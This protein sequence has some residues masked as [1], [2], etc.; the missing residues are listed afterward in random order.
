M[1]TFCASG[2]LSKFAAK[3][4]TDKGFEAYSLQG[5]MK[6]WN[7]AFD[8]A[9]LEFENFKIIQIRRNAKGC[10]S[11]IIGSKN[12]ALV[13]DAS[14]DPA[15]Y[16]NIA[17]NEGWK[18]DFVTDTHIHADY[19]SRTKDLSSFTGAAH[20]LNSVANVEYPFVPFTNNEI[21]LIGDIEIKTISTPGHTWESTTFLV[22][23]QV[24]LT[25]DTLFTDGIGRPDLKAGKKEAERKSKTLYKS[26]ELIKSFADDI[27]ILPAHI[28]DPVEIGQSAIAKTLGQVKKAVPALS[29]NIE[30][31]VENIMKKIPP[32]PPN[33]LTI[34]KINKSGKLGDFN[35]SELEAGANRCAIR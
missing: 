34:T 33:Y 3:V 28:S 1:V 16:I 30:H 32:T 8:T 17:K 35:I 11:Y 14:L 24:L 19:V 7:Y 13:V 27:L 21:I 4:L 9:V 20:L 25:G 31:F 10:L 22:D 12:T 23:N 15:I 6:A 18:I 5:G 29:F 2:N 26:L